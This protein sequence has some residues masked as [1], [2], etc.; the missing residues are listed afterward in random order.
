MQACDIIKEDE[1]RSLACLPPNTTNAPTA[2]TDM[3]FT[4]EFFKYLS[5]KPPTKHR[6]FMVR[7]FWK[8]TNR[9]FEAREYAVCAID[10]RTGEYIPTSMKG[11]GRFSDALHT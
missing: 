4:R 9:D 3:V 6:T 1:Q 2:Y 11:P 5:I 7:T 8:C 10:R